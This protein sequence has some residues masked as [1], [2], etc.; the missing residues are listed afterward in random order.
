QAGV[1]QSDA[2][3][4][5]HRFD[6]IQVFAVEIVSLE[7][8]SQRDVRDNPILHS[9]RNEVVEAQLSQLEKQIGLFGVPD[10]KRQIGI[11]GYIHSANKSR[12]EE[13]FACCVLHEDG[14]AVYGEC[15]RESVDDA[16]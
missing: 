13:R 6:Q 3:V 7:S 4:V 12:N 15:T 10:E 16:L 1:F 11:R 14:H 5:R 9:A 8:L 2:D